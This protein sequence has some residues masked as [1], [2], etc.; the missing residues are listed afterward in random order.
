[1]FTGSN[2]EAEFSSSCTHRIEEL[3]QVS[4]PNA[5]SNDVLKSPENLPVTLENEVQFTFS[6]P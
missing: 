1:M 3:S 6:L 4:V 2:Q 5:R